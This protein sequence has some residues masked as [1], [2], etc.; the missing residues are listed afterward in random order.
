MIPS[1][2][3]WLLASN[4]H[5][6]SF[7]Y[8]YV[9]MA[10]RECVRVLLLRQQLGA[11]SQLTSARAIDY[12]TVNRLC[13]WWSYSFWSV[14]FD[15]FDPSPD[16]R[17]LKAR[18]WKRRAVIT[19][20][21]SWGIGRVSW[22]GRVGWSTTA[23]MCNALLCFSIYSK[24][25]IVHLNLDWMQVT[26]TASSRVEWQPTFWSPTV[27]YLC[28]CASSLVSQSG[29][30]LPRQILFF[31]CPECQICLKLSSGKWILWVEF[32]WN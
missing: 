25:V 18:Q 21:K 27:G 28:D 2:S 16:W 24:I 1:C 26:C 31:F 10:T 20:Q 14:C 30:P 8:G 5:S 11:T 17:R 23:A 6:S 9:W 19:R 15:W 4:R 12:I 32:E 13:S 7:R 22:W 29:W 3:S